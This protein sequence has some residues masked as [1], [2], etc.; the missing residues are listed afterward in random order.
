MLTR[1]VPVSTVCWQLGLDGV[2]SDSQIT[3]EQACDYRVVSVDGVALCLLEPF[4]FFSI[5]MP[6]DV[7]TRTW[8]GMEK[9]RER[10]GKDNLP[11]KKLLSAGLLEK[12]G[13]TGPID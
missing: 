12:D 2:E 7:R 5:Y 4:S 1:S 6:S 9:E 13:W 11:Y 10:R 3:R 8:E